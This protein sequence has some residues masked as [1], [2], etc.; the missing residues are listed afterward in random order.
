MNPLT[1]KI[2]D[3]DRS[4]VS[5]YLLDMCT[6]SGRDC[7]TSLAIFTKINSVLES[8]SIPWSNCVGFGV[9]NTSVNLG[10]RHS[11]MTHVQ[12]RN[13]SCYFNYGLSMPPNT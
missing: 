4:Q 2:F 10:L 7:G 13:G 1:V 8:L 11:I 12:Q 6:T 5:T 3:T 9:D